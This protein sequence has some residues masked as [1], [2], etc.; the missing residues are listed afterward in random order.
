MSDGSITLYMKVELLQVSSGVFITQ[1]EYCNQVPETFGLLNSIPIS[2][3]MA[4]R[5]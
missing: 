3:P 1:R 2:T 4:E 5:P